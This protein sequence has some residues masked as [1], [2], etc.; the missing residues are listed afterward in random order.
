M[1]NSTRHISTCDLCDEYPDEVQVLEPM[2]HN[3]G[4]REAFGGEISTVKCFE[5][6]SFVKQR[7]GEPGE[8]RVLVVDGGASIRRALLGGDV[9]TMG[10]KNGWS[11]VIIYGCVRDVDEL[12]EIDLGIQ[13]LGVVPMKTKKRNVGELDVPLNFGGANFHHGYRVYA[14]NNGVIVAER[15]L[16]NG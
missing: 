16:L 15:D 1:T 9:A 7:L 10:A 8:G 14:D 3:F 13:A 2:L 4:G 6:N 12:I 5:D 11:G